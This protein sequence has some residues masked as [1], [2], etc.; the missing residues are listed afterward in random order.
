MNEGTLRGTL[1]GQDFFDLWHR[2][3]IGVVLRDEDDHCSSFHLALWTVCETCELLKGPTSFF[4]MTTKV[5]ANRL[6]K[7]GHLQGP[8]DLTDLR[9]ANGCKLPQHRADPHTIRAFF[10]LFQIGGHGDLGQMCLTRRKK[11]TCVVCFVGNVRLARL[12]Q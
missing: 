3:R 1:V 12:L 4:E 6:A 2:R 9:K 10:P 5:N 11:R 8:T 7:Y